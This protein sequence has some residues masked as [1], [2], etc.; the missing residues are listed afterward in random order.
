MQSRA[1]AVTPAVLLGPE[2][3]PQPITITS[4]DAGVLSYFDANRQLRQEPVEKL[5]QVRE[6]GG[7]AQAEPPSPA[8][9]M[10]EL[11]DDQRLTGRWVGVSGAGDG[12]IWEHP[13]LGS[14]VVPL[15]RIRYVALTDQPPAEL[16]Q[17]PAEAA[18]IEED[19]LVL[20]NGDELRGLVLTLAPHGLSILTTAEHPI[21]VPLAQV[22]WMELANEPAQPVAGAHQVLLRDGS[23]LLARE[24]QI[25]QDRLRFRSPLSDRAEQVAVDLDQVAGI[26]FTGAGRRLIDLLTCPR[27]ISGGEVFGVPMPPR[28]RDDALLLHAPVQVRFTLPPGA[29]RLTASASLTDQG[30]DTLASE[31]ADVELLIDAGAG[32]AQQHRLNRDQSQVQINL[33]LSGPAITVELKVGANGPVMDRVRLEAAVLVQE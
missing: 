18:A 14:M 22:R 1:Q 28:A 4:L 17:R 26:D 27:Q 9:P 30:P 33:P 13:L 3:E 7:A 24:V 15:E 20:A 29:Q 16:N 10:L 11:T 21:T 2:L 19:R 23:R 25:A 8:G 31:W 12:V 5:V 6:L 32:Q